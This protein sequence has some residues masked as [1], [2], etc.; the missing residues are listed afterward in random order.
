MR[1]KVSQVYG[2]KAGW[3]YVISMLIFATFH[4]LFNV[5]LFA[6]WFPSSCLSCPIPGVKRGLSF[7]CPGRICH[8]P[9]V[10]LGSSV[11]LDTRKAQ[12]R[13]CQAIGFPINTWA[14]KSENETR[15]V[16]TLTFSVRKCV[17]WLILLPHYRVW[18][19]QLTVWLKPGRWG[20]ESQTCLISSV[21]GCNEFM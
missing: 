20:L 4:R 10:R 7:N 9:L 2:L 19:S 13:E 3:L 6:G 18:E 14:G 17:L 12:L 8:I 15:T 21:Y 1:I 5:E 11:C 16:A